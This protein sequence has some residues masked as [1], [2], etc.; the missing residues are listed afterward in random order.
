MAKV[1]NHRIEKLSALLDVTLLNVEN[2]NEI[3]IEHEIA[4]NEASGNNSCS[5]TIKVE[6]LFMSKSNKFKVNSSSQK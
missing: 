5:S 4:I 2:R 6:P 3:S 1:M